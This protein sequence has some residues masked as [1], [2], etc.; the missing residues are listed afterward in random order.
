MNCPHC[1]AP[2]ID[3]RYDAVSDMTNPRAFAK[4]STA[5]E[6]H[7]TPETLAELWGT[8]E[9]SIRRTFD[10]EPGV[11]RL[12]KRGA[13]RRAMRIPKSVAERMH[14]QMVTK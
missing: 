9:R 11:L 3:E 2:D 10:G 5:H 4:L 1:G 13:L 6:Q 14:R 8:S 12:G 7:Y